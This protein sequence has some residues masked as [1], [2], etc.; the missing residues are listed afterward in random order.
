MLAKTLLTSA[1]LAFGILFVQSGRAQVDGR[2]EKLPVP[3]AA[4][5]EEALS[6]VREVFA[7]EYAAAKTSEQKASLA[8]KILQTATTDEHDPTNRY[9]LLRVARDIAA[10]AG[11]A[12]TALKATDQLDQ[13][14][15][16][17]AVAMKATVLAKVAD[18]VRLP[19]DHKRF[20]PLL[21]EAFEEAVAAERYGLARELGELAVAS[22]AKT[23]DPKARNAV[24]GKLKELE[25]L[26]TEFAKI[27]D[28]LAVLEEKPI[29]PDAN[30]AVGK[31]RCF[32]RGDWENGLPNLALGSDEELRKLAERELVAP[33][34]TA[35]QVKVADGW[36]AAAARED[37]ITK[38]KMQGRA[39]YW[40]KRALPGLE[41]FAK[42]KVEK[43]LKQISPAKLVGLP[44]DAVSFGR[45]HYKVFAGN[46]AWSDAKKKCE[47]MGGYLACP[48][49]PD[50]NSFL[51][52]L[53][54]PIG[55]PVWLGGTDAGREGTWMW[56]SGKPFRYRT[57]RKGE[58]SNSQ[59]KEHFMWLFPASAPEHAGRWNDAPNSTGRIKGF[60]CEWAF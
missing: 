16:V 11:D 15:R 53:I 28:A 43:R 5:M 36:W 25:Q 38:E 18:K 34:S 19:D 29:D 50:E 4:R 32:F 55:E 35:D 60:V 10:M 51:A 54:I 2:S 12:E 39:G 40:Y 8:K 21:G 14:Y 47:E 42:L 9:A 26:E 23:R 24:T 13:R 44:K 7:E 3:E 59:G 57:W 6:L 33:S 48:E 30:T 37:S 1:V 52:K 58:P 17:D 46:I 45:H 27:K 56:L 20:L 31:Y 22:A 41:G 49:T